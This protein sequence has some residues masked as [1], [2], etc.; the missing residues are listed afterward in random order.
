M[1]NQPIVPIFRNHNPTFQSSIH[2]WKNH[3]PLQKVGFGK[4][5]AT[6]HNNEETL[7]MV[8]LVAPSKLE[9]YLSGQHVSKLTNDIVVG[10]IVKNKA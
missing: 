5:Q 2:L 7:M 10:L 4:I 6:R 1:G 3:V 9:N 8:A